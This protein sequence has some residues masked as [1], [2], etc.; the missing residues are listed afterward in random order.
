MYYYVKNIIQTSF[1]G[2]RS[3]INFFVDILREF[4]IFYTLLIKSYK[5]VRD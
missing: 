1:Q 5:G 2:S 4:D 3:T